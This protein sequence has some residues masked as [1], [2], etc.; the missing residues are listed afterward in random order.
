MA[1]SVRLYTG[2][3]TGLAATAQSL[4]PTKIIPS[5]REVIVQADPDNTTDVLVGN[6][7]DQF[8]KLVRGQGISIPLNNLYSIY[9]KMESAT[10]GTV[11]WIARD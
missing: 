2:Q 6:S 11:S 1:Q 5:I 9:V 10:T 7:V 8:L 4:D 3:I